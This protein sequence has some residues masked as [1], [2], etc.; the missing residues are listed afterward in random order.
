M[1]EEIAL[2]TGSSEAA[3]EINHMLW[4]INSASV[5]RGGN[6][7]RAHYDDI[8]QAKIIAKYMRQHGYKVS[9][10]KGNIEVNY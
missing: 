3:A 8:E 2:E 4:V 6:V 10:T 9:R 1:I 5:A 7:L